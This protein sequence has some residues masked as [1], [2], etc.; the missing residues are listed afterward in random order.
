LPQLWWRRRM[1]RSRLHLCQAGTRAADLI[2]LC[3]ANSPRSRR[4]ST[5]PERKPRQPLTYAP[6]STRTGVVAT[7]AAT[8]PTSPRTRGA[9]DPTSP[10]L[11]PRVR[12]S[13][14]RPPDHGARGART[15]RC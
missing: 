11:Q 5:S 4:R 8:R 15:P 10:L 3:I 13:R 9:G 12:S 14:R 6:T 1:R 7:P 2:G